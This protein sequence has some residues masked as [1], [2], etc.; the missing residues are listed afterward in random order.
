MQVFELH[1]TGEVWTKN[2]WGILISVTEKI[3]PKSKCKNW[4]E[5]GPT[6]SLSLEVPRVKG[7]IMEQK[8]W[9][10]SFYNSC[11]CAVQCTVYTTAMYL[12]KWNIYCTLSFVI[13]AYDWLCSHY[14]VFN[15]TQV[16]TFPLK[17]LKCL[18]IFFAKIC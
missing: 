17:G 12:V 18:L 10:N 14:L 8:P 4:F 1:Y 5:L 2:L 7:Q 3:F 6:F 9:G 15:S 16:A 13:K 11:Q